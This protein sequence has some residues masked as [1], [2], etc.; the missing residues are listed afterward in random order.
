MQT[1][2]I[3]LL[4]GFVA[5]AGVLAAPATEEKDAQVLKYDNDHNGIDGYNFQF[6]TSNGIQRQEQAQLK[7]FDDENSA[8]VVRGSYSFTADDGQVY[9]VN[10]VAD[11][12]GF[13][14]EAPHL[15][16]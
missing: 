10:Y 4:V 11:E 7:Q 1:S 16:K 14:P 8:L 15:P 6:D 2:T 13:Q 12:N 5:A 3:V 9:T